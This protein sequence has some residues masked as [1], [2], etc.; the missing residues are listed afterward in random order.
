MV[1]LIPGKKGSGKTK[2]LIS[3]IHDAEKK[4]DGNVVAVQIGS[5]LNVDIYHKIRLVNIEDYKVRSYDDMFG[6]IAGVLASDYDCTDIFIDGLL[7]IVGRDLDEI[8]RLCERVSEICGDTRVTCT[9]SADVENMPESVKK[10][11]S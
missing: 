6:F 8:G 5:S 4:S 10:Y 3:A 11:V 7:R 9:I 2:L 1:K